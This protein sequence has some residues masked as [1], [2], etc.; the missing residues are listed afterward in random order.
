MT[1]PP[2][3][4][5][6]QGRK[7][8]GDGG[9]SLSVGGLC[10]AGGLPVGAVWWVVGMSGQSRRPKSVPST[11]E[12]TEERGEEGAKWGGKRALG[13]ILGDKACRVWLRTSQRRKVRQ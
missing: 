11:W 4:Q 10:G 3:W 6:W 12:A 5:A 8:G 9:V 7:G 1:L 2:M 13:R